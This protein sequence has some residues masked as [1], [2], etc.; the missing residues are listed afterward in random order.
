MGMYWGT[1]ENLGRHLGNMLGTIGNDENIVGTPN[2]T[3]SAE[4]SFLLCYCATNN[5]FY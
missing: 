5:I 3:T 4:W 2:L 1:H